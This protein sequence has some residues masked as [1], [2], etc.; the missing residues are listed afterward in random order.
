MSSLEYHTCVNYVQYLVIQLNMY[1][2]HVSTEAVEEVREQIWELV[3]SSSVGSGAQTRVSRLVWQALFL[4]PSLALCEISTFHR[5]INRQKVTCSCIIRT[6]GD[7]SVPSLL[8]V[9]L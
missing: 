4:E 3:L 2:M 9:L 7:S 8:S 5:C 1:V 6:G